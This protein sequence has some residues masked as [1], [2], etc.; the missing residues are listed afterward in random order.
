LTADEQRVF[1]AGTVSVAKSQLDRLGSAGEQSSHDVISQP[2]EPPFKPNDYLQ[3][4]EMEPPC[5]PQ[6]NQT[7]VEGLIISLERVI[8]ILDSALMKTLTWLCAEK[9][10]Y[11]QKV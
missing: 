1:S 5:D 9:S 4:A 11:D 2:E 3:K 10:N 6:G 8:E 7:M